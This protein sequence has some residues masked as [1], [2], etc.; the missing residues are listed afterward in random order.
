MFLQIEQT[1]KFNFS[2]YNFNL[3]IFI[4][5]ISVLFTYKQEI[6]RTIDTPAGRHRPKNRANTDSKIPKLNKNKENS[7]SFSKQREEVTIKTKGKYKPPRKALK[8]EEQKV[9]LQTIP[10]RHV[11]KPGKKHLKNNLILKIKTS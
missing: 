4:Y 1:K 5:L 10:I 6:K 8:K 3:K 9:D 11:S 7:G 2:F